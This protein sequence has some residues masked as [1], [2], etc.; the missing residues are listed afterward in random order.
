[1]QVFIATLIIIA[2]SWKKLKCPSTVEWIDKML[3]LYN[4]ILQLIKRNEPWGSWMPQLF[5]VRALN[6]K[7]DGRL[8]VV[9]LL[10]NQKLH[11]DF[12]LSGVVTPKRHSTQESTVH[13]FLLNLKYLF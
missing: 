5:R 7:V 4:R 9:K 6:D 10:W 1:M 8:T 13:I 2:K 12:Q 3:Y 11:T